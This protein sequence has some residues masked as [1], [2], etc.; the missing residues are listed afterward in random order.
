MARAASKS[1]SSSPDDMVKEAVAALSKKGERALEEIAER[2]QH[3]LDETTQRIQETYERAA[4]PVRDHAQDA[5]QDAW[6]EARRSGREGLDAT[7]S[8]ARENPMVIGL[9]G[10]ATGLMLGVLL[11]SCRR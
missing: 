9:T 3:Y 5:F 7:Q 11:M 6:R 8:I 2:S 1:T 10:L 4:E